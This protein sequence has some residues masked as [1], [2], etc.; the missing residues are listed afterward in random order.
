MNFRLRH[1][2]TGRLVV[3]KEMIQKDHT[4]LTVGLSEHLGIDIV[5][6]KSGNGSKCNLN[7]T[8][9]DYLNDLERYSIFRLISTGLARETDIKANTSVQI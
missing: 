4:I 5:V 1:L 6:N 3:M 2:N 9:M 8:N 7:C